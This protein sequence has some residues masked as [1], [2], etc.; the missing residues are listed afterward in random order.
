MVINIGQAWI[1][2]QV[3]KFKH[4]GKGTIKSSLAKEDKSIL[5]EA[6]NQGREELI[7]V[8]ATIQGGGVVPGTVVGAVSTTASPH[9]QRKAQ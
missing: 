6:L 5:K 8:L 2:D 7:G 3:L 1:Q 9:G 4:R